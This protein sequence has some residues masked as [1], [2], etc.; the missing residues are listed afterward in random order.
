MKGNTDSLTATC[1]RS[2]S[3]IDAQR[4]TLSPSI[5]RVA[6]LASG[7]PMALET[8]GTVREARGFTSST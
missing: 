4:S 1:R 6:T 3:S 2:T 5:A 7:T 8:N